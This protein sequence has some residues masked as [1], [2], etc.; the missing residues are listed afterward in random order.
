MTADMVE[1]TEFPQIAQKY[2]VRGV[3]RTMING[4]QGF[5]GAVP[6]NAFVEMVVSA[7]SGPPVS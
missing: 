4:E 3:P 7:A 2:H 5:D 6:E 1:L